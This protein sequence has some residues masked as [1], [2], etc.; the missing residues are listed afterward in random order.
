MPEELMI[1]LSDE[2]IRLLYKGRCEV[3]RICIFTF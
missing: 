2:D 3:Q 1:A